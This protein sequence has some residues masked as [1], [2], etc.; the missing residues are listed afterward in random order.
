M[1]LGHGKALQFCVSKR[2]SV[3][4]SGQNPAPT[5]GSFIDFVRVCVPGSQVD[6]ARQ[7]FEQ[8]PH[9]VQSEST[10][11]LSQLSIL[12]SP[13]SDIEVQGLPPWSVGVRTPR[14]L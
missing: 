7:A 2:I 1:F 10:Q 9:P 6:L 4:G 5:V 3:L 11:S 14:A 8:G 12:H 13:D